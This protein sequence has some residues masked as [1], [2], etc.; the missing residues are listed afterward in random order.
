MKIYHHFDEA[1]NAIEETREKFGKIEVLL[2]RIDSLLE[3]ATFEKRQ[4]ERTSPM[5]FES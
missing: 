4:S 5:L 1:A 2:E 3:L